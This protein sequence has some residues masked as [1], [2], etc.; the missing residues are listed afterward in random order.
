MRRR[1][2]IL[3]GIGVGG[4]LIVG[5]GVL[6]PRSRL[7]A[8]GT[9]PPLEGAVSL[10]GW[11]RIAADG[12]AVIAV[13]RSEMGQ[14]VYTSL[15]MLV[16]EELGVGLAQIRVEQAPIDAIFGNVAVLTT[17]LPFPPDREGTGLAR[18]SE[19]V[20]A[21]LARELDLQV[22]GGSTSVRDAW[23]PMRLAGAAARAMLVAAAAKHWNAAPAQC[24]VVDGEVRHLDGR[25]VALRELIGA[26]REVP[27]PSG[28][29]LKR[30]QDFTLI[31]KPAPRLDVPD[32]VTGKARYGIDVRLPGM[33]FAALRACPT[34]GG[35]LRH[36]DPAPALAQ[37]GVV[38][39]SSLPGA[40]GG[41]PA[42]AVVARSWWTDRKSV[43]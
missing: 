40:A 16:A 38:R 26:L 43:V 22:T 42:V 33:L 10:N 1:S 8:R 25:R 28:V 34:F 7:G 6:P 36:V 24:S 29:R 23:Q 11:V 4:A 32:K 2:F 9:L 31:G 21:K 15:P 37:P 27:L 12:T 18:A 5:W 13:P 20:V 3:G 17:N 35:T 41:G 14:G 30:P 19:W 39:V